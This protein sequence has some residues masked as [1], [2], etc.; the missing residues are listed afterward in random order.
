MLMC[1]LY[2][3]GAQG[4]TL[5]RAQIVRDPITSD[6]SFNVCQQ[7][8]SPSCYFACPL[9]DEALCIDEKTGARYI[10][11]GECIGCEMC[12]EAC[13]FN[14]SRIKLNVEKKIAFKCDLCRGREGGP[15]CVEYC[16]MEALKFLPRDER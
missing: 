3:E 10:N 7:C 12:I 16:P 14:P 6:V 9:R 11:E 5:S 13:P 2:H 4:L 15:I 8:L 1:S